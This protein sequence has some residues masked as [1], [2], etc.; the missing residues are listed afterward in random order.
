MKARLAG[1]LLAVSVVIPAKAAVVYVTYTGT[2]SAGIDPG[3]VFGQ[4]GSLSGKS[5]TVSYVFDT[6]LGSA[7]TNSV[8]DFRFGGTAFGTASPLLDPAVLTIGGFSINIKGNLVGEI[9]GTNQGAD[10]F[11]EQLHRAYD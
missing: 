2:V 9:Q 1:F 5:Y 10:A 4:A 11:S 8:E 7:V 3:G 6:S